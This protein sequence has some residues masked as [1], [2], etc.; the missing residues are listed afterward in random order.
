M[1]KFLCSL[2]ALGIGA[3]S[4]LFADEEVVQ[5]ARGGF[6]YQM[7]IMIGLALVFFYF[8]VLRPERKRRKAMDARR[9]SMKKGDRVTAMGIRGTIF[10]I[11]NDSVVIKLY[12]GA[13][14]EILKAAITEVEATSESV[15][16]AKTVELAETQS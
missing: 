8:I 3:S 4:A 15:P 2:A 12:D 13:K 11:E 16:E 9:S 7:L 14:M 5:A 1:K 10:K 6:N